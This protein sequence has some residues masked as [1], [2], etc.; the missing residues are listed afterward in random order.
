MDRIT[1]GNG[2]TFFGEVNAKHLIKAL[3]TFRWRFIQIRGGIR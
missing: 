3:S 2:A 1:A